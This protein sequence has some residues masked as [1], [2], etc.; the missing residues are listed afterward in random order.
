VCSSFSFLLSF[1]HLSKS[2]PLFS[3]CPF[4]LDHFKCIRAICECFPNYKESILFRFTIGSADSETL[5]FWEPNAPDF[6]E[7]LDCLRIA[8][9]CGFQTSISGEPMLDDDME[10]LVELVTPFITDSIWIGKAN[11]LRATLKINGVMDADTLEKAN[12]L[13]E[14]QSDDNIL[15]LYDRLKDNPQ[16]KWKES[17]KKVVGIPLSTESGM[18]V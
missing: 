1:E 14:W 16:I 2:L 18:D 6:P 3:K 10:Q 11:R 17:I 4:P 15:A 12:Q 13:L 8:H 9:E 7:R 5:R